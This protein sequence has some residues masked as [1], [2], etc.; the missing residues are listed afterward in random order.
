M[1]NEKH[2]DTIGLPEKGLDLN[3]CF[4]NKMLTLLPDQ[5]KN[6]QQLIKD[7]IGNVNN[8][9]QSMASDEVLSD[10]EFAGHMGL[11]LGSPKYNL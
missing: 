3:N 5:H 6:L 2:S 11:R 1:L 4:N 7:L 10:L 8:K 9:H